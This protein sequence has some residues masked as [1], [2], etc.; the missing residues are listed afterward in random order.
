MWSG[1]HYTEKCMSDPRK[2]IKRGISKKVRFLLNF[3]DLLQVRNRDPALTVYCCY[4]HKVYDE[5]RLSHF[6]IK[7]GR[8]PQCS[9]PQVHLT[10]GNI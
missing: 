1:P 4:I 9:S 10:M 8:Q 6:K 3:C 2:I 5:E 7:T